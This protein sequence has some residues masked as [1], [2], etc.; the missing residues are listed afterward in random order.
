M[1]IPFHAAVWRLIALILCA[2]ATE[3]VFAAT[4]NASLVHAANGSLSSFSGG[5]TAD[6]ATF[7]SVHRGYGSDKQAFR[8]Q[9]P[10]TAGSGTAYGALAVSWA[11]GQTVTY[12]AA[13]RLP[14]GFHAATQ[15]QQLL[16]GWSSAPG[17]D[18]STQQGGV[19]IDYS[20]NLGYLVT[21]TTSSAGLTQQVL[22]G[23]FALPIG[24]WFTLQVRQLLASTAPAHS[25]VSVN[26]RLVASSTASDFSGQ[27]IDAVN[28][29]IVQ[30]TGGADSGAVSV[31][32]DRALA[33]VYRGYLNPLRGDQYVTGRTDMGVDFCLAPGEP[34]HALGDG[35][36]VGISPDWFRGQPYIWY[37]LVDG[38]YAGRF[39]YVAEQIGKLA[40]VGSSLTAGQTIARYNRTGTCIE[41]GWSAADGATLAQATTG[42]HEGQ[43]TRAGVSFARFLVTLGVGGGLELSSRYGKLI[44]APTGTFQDPWTQ[45]P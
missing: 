13:F 10:G 39:V 31:Q 26:G 8:A 7:T 18:G 2:C 20:D 42:Y 38:P 5:V 9:Y 3:F 33:A 36:V 25:T 44:P 15:G 27:Q 11:P 32:F 4:G 1:S 16:L 24:R 22:A 29:G 12:G 23:P 30:L 35:V 45:G 41:M 14:H 19:V 43:V 6:N 34:I 21:N 40:Q 28:Y 17:T 37:Q